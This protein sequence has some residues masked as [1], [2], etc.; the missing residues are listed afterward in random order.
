LSLRTS[1]LVTF[2][3]AIEKG[4]FTKAAKALGITDGGAS[5]HIK[6]LELFFNT[7]LFTRT[8]GGSKLTEEGK[9]VY[10]FAKDFLNS[11][12]ATKRQ[13]MDMRKVLRGTIRIGASTIPG[14]HIVPQLINSFK[15]KHQGVDFVIHVSDTGE[16][17]NRLKLGEADMAAVGSLILVPKAVEYEKKVIGE[18]ELVIIVPPDHKLSS[19]E[20]VSIR[21]IVPLPFISREKGSGTRAEVE[22]ILKNAGVDT[23]S[24]NIRLELGSTESVITAVSEGSGISIV[25]ETAARKVEKAN[26]IKILKI[27]GVDNRRQLYLIKD[28]QKQLSKPAKL[29]WEQI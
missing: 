16:A 11:L 5:H 4:S 13:I 6:T 23:T 27:R 15:D 3:T 17:F 9:I 24:L 22:R 26:L 18:E 12:D 1:Y 2:I 29:F 21:D 10:S 8:A 28:P 20:T 19:Q 14:E 25:S 7:E